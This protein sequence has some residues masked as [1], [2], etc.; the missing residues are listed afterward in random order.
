MNMR[1]IKAV[2]DEARLKI[3]ERISRGEICSCQLPCCAC[4]SQ[5]ATSQHLKILLNAGLVKVEKRGKHRVYSTTR[6]GSQIVKDIS[7]W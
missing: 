2:S 5:P 6:K 1:T 4:I 3:L 7:R